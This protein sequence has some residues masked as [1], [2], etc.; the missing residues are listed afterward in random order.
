[1]KVLFHVDQLENWGLTLK[2]VLNMLEYAQQHK[3]TF[4][5]AVVANA[6]AVVQLNSK[7]AKLDQFDQI[8]AKKKENKVEFLAC[9]N[10]LKGFGMAP[11]DLLPFVA[12]VPAGVVEI[13]LRQSDGY[14]YIKP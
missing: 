4:E 5:I 14:A 9:S 12:V 6:E 8:E 1:M 3:T 11:A 7:S 13:A 10:A 2:N